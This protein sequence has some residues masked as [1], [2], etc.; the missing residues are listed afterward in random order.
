MA[1]R[2][3]A[4]PKVEA[5]PLSD[6]MMKT[7]DVFKI[8]HHGLSKGAFAQV[9]LIASGFPNV[10]KEYIESDDKEVFMADLY[11]YYSKK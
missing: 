3:K 10:R 7:M 1:T 5:Q 11:E 6:D 2:K 9:L 8:T 4:T